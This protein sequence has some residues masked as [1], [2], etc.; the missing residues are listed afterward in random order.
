MRA[1]PAVWG[2]VGRPVPAPPPA[3][4]PPPR[5]VFRP[6]RTVVRFTAACP[7]CGRDTQWETTS[8]PGTPPAVNCPCTDEEA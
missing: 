1:F 2:L 3:P 8:T 5:P 6:T 7:A 4:S